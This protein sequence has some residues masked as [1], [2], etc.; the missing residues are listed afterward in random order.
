MSAT[1]RTTIKFDR[2]CFYN[3]QHNEQVNILI[4]YNLIDFLCIFSTKCAVKRACIG[5]DRQKI[6]VCI[7]LSISLNIC[8]GCSK[9]PSQ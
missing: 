7:F 9:E 4:S 1:A 8:F 6:S 3:L 2:M 5:P